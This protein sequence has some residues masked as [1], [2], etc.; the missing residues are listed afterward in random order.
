ML[1]LFAYLAFVGAM[2]A[3]ILWGVPKLVNRYIRWLF[4]V[5]HNKDLE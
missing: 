3:L 1:L 2:F 5:I 4:R